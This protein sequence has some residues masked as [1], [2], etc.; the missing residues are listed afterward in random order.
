MRELTV[1]QKGVCRQGNGS[2]CSAVARGIFPH[3]ESGQVLRLNARILPMPGSRRAAVTSTYSVCL[4]GKERE[5]L[6]FL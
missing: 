5:N 2:L 6:T 3:G 4:H 1:K